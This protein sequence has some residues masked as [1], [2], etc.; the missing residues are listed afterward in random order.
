M[1]A[2]ATRSITPQK[3]FRPENPPFWC[4][5]IAPPIGLPVRTP[6]DEMA[7]KSP[8]R[9]P[10]F[11]MSEIWATK[12]GMMDKT[13]PEVN[14]YKAAKT[15]RGALAVVGNQIASV[16][17]PERNVKMIMTLNTPYTSPK[18]RGMIRPKILHKIWSALGTTGIQSGLPC[19]IDDWYQIAGQII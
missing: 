4:V 16:K 5:T 17:S 1:D 2:A 19:G 8:T 18:W 11:R 9:V 12:A 14:P 3:I 13:Q 6:N 15:M 10:I 7:Y